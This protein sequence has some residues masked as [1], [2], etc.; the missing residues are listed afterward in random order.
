MTEVGGEEAGTIPCPNCGAAV[1]VGEARAE[2]EAQ[3]RVTCPT[4]GTPVPLGEDQT[5][6]VSPT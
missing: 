6:G 4:C 1:P 3:A 2:G 5:R